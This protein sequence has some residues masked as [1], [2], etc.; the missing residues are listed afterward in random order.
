MILY[1]QR[2]KRCESAYMKVLRARSINQ[3]TNNR[4]IILREKSTLKAEFLNIF[5]TKSNKL[6]RNVIANYT[7]LFTDYKSQ[8]SVDIEY[9]IKQLVNTHTLKKSTK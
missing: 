5:L 8:R 6:A 1:R 9:V 7:N 3:K 2:Y 4:V